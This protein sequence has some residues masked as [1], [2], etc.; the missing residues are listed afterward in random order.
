[1]IVEKQPSN[2]T[3]SIKASV[4]MPTFERADYALAALDSILAQETSFVFEVLVLD[5]ARDENLEKAVF[6]RQRAI[7]VPLRY[8]PVVDVGLHN[9]RHMAARLAK[10]ELLM[11]VDDDTIAHSFWLENLVKAFNDWEVHLAT[12]PLLPAYE[13]EVPTWL[14]YFWS[15]TSSGSGKGWCGYLS[16]L[17]L[18]DEQHQID[19]LLVFGANFAIRKQTLIDLGGFHPDSLPWSLRRFRGDGET[20]ISLAAKARGLK[21]LY[22]PGARI[23]HR[24]PAGRLKLEYFERRAFLQGISDSFSHIRQAPAE[25]RKHA[26]SLQEYV[27]RL[28]SLWRYFRKATQRMQSV[29]LSPGDERS[30]L[31]QRMENCRLRGYEYHQQLYLTNVV[32][33]EWVERRHYWDGRVPVNVDGEGK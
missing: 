4:A 30:R 3:V 13:G 16:L 18:G 23:S 1:M 27:S 24:V 19:P 25:D 11:F 8:V 17:E 12:G 20:A 21:A 32:V 28:S 33:K 10:G 15:T 22:V 26:G 9:G 6:E 14:D 31:L 5:N 2:E 7:D 29:T